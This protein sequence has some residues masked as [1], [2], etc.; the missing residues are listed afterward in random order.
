MGILIIGLAVFL[1]AHSVSIV[2]PGW[3][4]R[5]VARV[6]VRAWQAIY[7]VIALVGLLL[8]VH[9]YGVARAASTI[10]YVPP[11]WL[12]DVTAVLMLAVFP[13][14]LATYLPG[15]IQRTVKHP[16]LLAVKIWAL[17]HLLANGSLADVVLFGSLILWAGA[18]RMSVKRRAPRRVPGAPPA[19]W[20][21]AAAIVAGLGLYA[22][23]VLDLHQRLFGVSP[24][25]F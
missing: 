14:L 3:R 7:S 2:N 20:N 24:L 15:R 19:P 22:A 12:R 21:D 5:V 25:G 11:L 23:F 16:M 18:D 9:G 4:D 8:I 17:A 10:L 13:L 1:G 6:G